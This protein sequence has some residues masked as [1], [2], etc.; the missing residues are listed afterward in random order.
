[1]WQAWH[2]RGVG[3]QDCQGAE[4][5]V[6]QELVSLP[7]SKWPREPKARGPPHAPPVAALGGHCRGVGLVWSPAGV[8]LAEEPRLPPGPQTQSSLRPGL[9]AAQLGSAAG[10]LRAAVISLQLAWG[11]LALQCPWPS[12]TGPPRAASAVPGCPMG[13]CGFPEVGSG[14]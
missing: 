10:S 3:T 12:D 6:P 14:N 7:L 4:G 2:W 9:S 13:A 5:E 1:M 8:R 11:G